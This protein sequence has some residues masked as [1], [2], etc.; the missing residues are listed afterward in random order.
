MFHYR[1]ILMATALVLAPLTTAE[2]ADTTLRMAT[3]VPVDSVEGRVHSRF[4]ELASEYTDGRV[5]ILVFPNNQV[6]NLD[7]SLEQLSL[8]V[9]HIFAEGL[10]NAKKW[11]EDLDWLAA[12]FLF[13]D[14]DHWVRFIE[15]PLVQ[16]WLQTVADDGGVIALGNGT[17]ID[18]G[19]F[20]VIVSTRP[21]ATVDDLNGLG[22]RLFSNQTQIEAWSHLGASTKVIPWTEV[23]Q[24]M[25]TGLIEATTSPL[26]LVQSMRF[27]EQAKNITRTDEYFQSVSYL[28]NKSAWDGMSEEDRAGVTK[29]Y[30]EAGEYS[31]E[32]LDEQA[33]TMIASLENVGVS[34]LEPDMQPFVE[35]LSDYYSARAARGQL[36]EGMME[37][38]EATRTAQ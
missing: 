1:K 25:Q 18:R 26:S 6:G 35:K 12:P 9:V 22:M 14:R 11:N 10:V 37:T 21:V 8:G 24:A 29:A 17:E 19:P 23:Y 32:L 2:A 36:P 38:L 13:E 20:R 34:Y 31:S 30:V 15:S 5:E 3:Q 4:A 7:A 33:R 28:V 27:Y 16:G